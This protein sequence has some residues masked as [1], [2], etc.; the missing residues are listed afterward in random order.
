MRLETGIAG[1]LKADLSKSNLVSKRIQKDSGPAR[2]KATSVFA[3]KEISSK[4]GKQPS[5]A[6]LRHGDRVEI[7]AEANDRIA[8]IKAR[9]NSGFYNNKQ[10]D[11]DISEKLSRYFDE[12]TN[13]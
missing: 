2:S 12:F 4:A 5:S 6:S 1:Y 9:V 11:D 10:V 13:K 7:S 8:R 3:K